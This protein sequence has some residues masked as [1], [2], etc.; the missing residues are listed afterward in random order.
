MLERLN[1]TPVDG[2]SGPSSAASGRCKVR[3]L[4]SSSDQDDGL[5]CVLCRVSAALCSCY[6]G[7]M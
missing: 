6:S 7:I 3:S 4:I 5:F 1:Q 2:S